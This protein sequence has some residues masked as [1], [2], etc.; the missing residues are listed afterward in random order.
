[1]FPV[2]VLGFNP[3]QK[4]GHIPTSSRKSRRISLTVLTPFKSPVISQLERI[5]SP[6]RGLVVLTPFKSPVIS[7][8]TT[9]WRMVS[10]SRGFNPVQKS[11][12]IP[13]PPNR[14]QEIP[15]RVLTPFKSPVISQRKASSPAPRRAS[16]FNPVQKSGHIPTEI[17]AD[18]D[19]AKEVLTPFK[20]PVISQHE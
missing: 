11:G 7:Q 9:T 12:H 15:M 5:G 18:M 4:S 1:M 10:I 17:L 3:V 13:T 2:V 19:S 8:R 16:C 14:W 20:S 6:W